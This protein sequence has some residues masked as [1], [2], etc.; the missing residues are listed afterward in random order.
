MSARTGAQL[1]GIMADV[2]ISYSR[3]DSDLVHWILDGLAEQNRDVW[4]DWEDIS[5]TSN[6]WK[7]ITEGIENADTFA[8]VMSPDSVASPTCNFEIAH[9]LQHNKRIVPIVCRDVAETQ[10]FA[11][12][13][14]EHLSESVL[15]ILGGRDLI[16]VAR[17]S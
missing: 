6:W 12:L 9:A 14:S 17:A 3:K 10:A 5:L 15:E 1:G 13:A 11:A 7:E 2:F 4:V 8:F 16:A